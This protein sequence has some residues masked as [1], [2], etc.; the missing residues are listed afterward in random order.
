MGLYLL[1][2]PLCSPL[3]PL[4]T[5]GRVINPKIGCSVDDDALDRHTESLVQALQAV[6]LE[7]LDDA[8]AQPRELPLARSFAHISRQP[9]PGEIQRVDEAEGGGTRGAPG[10][11][12]PGEVAPELLVPVHSP[13]ED[14]LVLVLE[15]EVE[16]L[17]GEVADDVGQVAPPEGDDALLLGD[18]DDAVDDAL[19]LLLRRDLFAGVL[20][21]CGGRE[22]EEEEGREGREKDTAPVTPRHGRPKGSA[23]AAWPGSRC[24]GSVTG[25][26][27]APALI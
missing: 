23:S 10:R 8:V 18:A 26:G 7:D 11:Q 3:H 19:V 14:L 21:L 9:G 17:G 1:D 4:L 5:L 22:E 25:A 24:P 12:V 15:G 6:G 2:L 16:G 13:Q 20:D 27:P